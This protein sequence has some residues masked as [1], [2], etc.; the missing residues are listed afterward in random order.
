MTLRH[1]LIVH[2]ADAVTDSDIQ[3]DLLYPPLHKIRDVSAAIAVAVAECAYRQG[4]A[5]EP[6][7]ADLPAFIASRMYHPA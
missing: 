1:S 7:P 5:H 2:C 4:L 3:Q 6:R